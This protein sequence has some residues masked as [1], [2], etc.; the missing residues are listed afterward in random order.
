MVALSYMH[1]IAVIAGSF[2]FGAAIGGVSLYQ[3]ACRAGSAY[4]LG[5]ATGD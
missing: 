2:L 1:I 3:F 5:N 4:A